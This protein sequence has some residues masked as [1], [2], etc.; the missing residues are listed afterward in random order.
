MCNGL[1]Q[2]KREFIWGKSLVASVKHEKEL[3]NIET[4]VISA[5]ISKTEDVSKLV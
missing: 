2:I 4:K 5:S 1:V 3:S